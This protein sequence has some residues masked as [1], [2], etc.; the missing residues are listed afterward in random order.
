[1]HCIARNCWVQCCRTPGLKTFCPPPSSTQSYKLWVAV[2]GEIPGM[3][4]MAL[5]T[6]AYVIALPE[7][8]LCGMVLY[9]TAPMLDNANLTKTTL[10]CPTMH[11][12]QIHTTVLSTVTYDNI[13]TTTKTDINNNSANYSCG[14]NGSSSSPSPPFTRLLA[15]S[16]AF[17]PSPGFVPNNKCFAKLPLG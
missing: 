12:T 13:E 15:S 11:I 9:N 4:S 2:A 3:L 5:L 17:N 14:D 1:M 7:R 6:C 16:M 8:A 10:H